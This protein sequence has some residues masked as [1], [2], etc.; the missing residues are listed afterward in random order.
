MEYSLEELLPVVE[1]LSVK[2]TSGESSSITYEAARQLMDAV[3]YCIEAPGSEGNNE[4]IPKDK[5]DAAAAYELGFNRIMAKVYKAREIYDGMIED[6]YDY[7]CRV[8]G[9]T[10][11]KGIPEFFINYDPKFNPRDHI[12]TL[13]YPTLRPINELSGIHAIYQY[14]CNIKM[15]WEFLG[16]FE[17]KCIEELL[18]RI[19]MDYR[20]LYY[21]NI[22]YAVLFT[23]LGCMTADKP[24]GA[25]KLNHGDMAAIEEF[26]RKDTAEKVEQK[27]RMLIVKLF[28]KA[29]QGNKDMKE[30]FLYSTSD[31]AVRILN[32]IKNNCLD[33]VFYLTSTMF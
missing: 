1:K 24:V 26:F 5:P 17:A 2:Y 11:I 14:L 22:S 12:L 15:E 8:C 9:E 13:D 20:N 32:G 19:M 28:D 10:I 29:F 27:I 3:L 7:Q 25:L 18:G 16:A 31:Y 30:Y 21:D 6:F 33:T 23:V 4:I